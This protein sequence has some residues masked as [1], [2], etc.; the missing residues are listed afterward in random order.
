MLWSLSSLVIFIPLLG[1]L[2]VL[3]VVDIVEANIPKKY[4]HATQ[5][6]YKR[7]NLI[8]IIMCYMYILI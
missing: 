1:M 6:Q 3:D 7:M 8:I 4:V 5:D 2:A